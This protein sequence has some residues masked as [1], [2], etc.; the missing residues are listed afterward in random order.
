VSKICATKV[1]LWFIRIKLVTDPTQLRAAGAEKKL[2]FKRGTTIVR[3][4]HV[5]KKV[6]YHNHCV[7]HLGKEKVKYSSKNF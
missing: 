3:I 5:L 2:K 4:L 1:T 6:N 7:Q